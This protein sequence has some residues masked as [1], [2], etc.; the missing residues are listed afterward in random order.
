[1]GAAVLSFFVPGLAHFILGKPIHGILW[2]TV[3]LCGYLALIFPGMI[4]HLLCMCDAARVSNEVAVDRMEAAM[5]RSQ[6][7]QV[8]DRTHSRL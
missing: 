5:R 1:M 7:M 2:F 6:K 4:L 3:T 8:V